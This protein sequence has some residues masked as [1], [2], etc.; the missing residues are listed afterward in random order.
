M[1]L[2]GQNQRSWCGD[3]SNPPG[4]FISTRVDANPFNGIPILEDWMILDLSAEVHVF[5]MTNPGSHVTHDMHIDLVQD[6]LSIENVILR[7]RDLLTNIIKET[8]NFAS[9]SMTA[10]FND[11]TSKIADIERSEKEVSDA[12]SNFKFHKI[13][14]ILS[15]MWKKVTN[16]NQLLEQLEN[17]LRQFKN[18]T[19]NMTTVF[20]R[21]ELTLLKDRITNVVGKLENQVTNALKDFSGAGLKFGMHL[22]IFG[23]NFGRIDGELV[24]SSDVLLRCSRF[25]GVK[26]LLQN[27]P[28]LR[29]LGRFSYETKLGFF[30]RCGN[31]AGIGVAMA[32][33]SN[34]LIVQVNGYINILGIK[35]TGDV[36]IS[37]QGV[38]FYI[39]GKVWNLF[40]AQLESHAGLIGTDWHGLEISVSGRFVAQAR[41]KRQTQTDTTN[42]EAS[43]LDALRKVVSNIADGVQKRLSQAQSALTYAQRKMTDAK[44]WLTEK[45]RD[46]RNANS[47]FDSAVKSFD[48][49]KDKL[50]AAKGPFRRAIEKLNS[51][52]RKVDNLCRIRHCKKIC[53]PG[54]KCKICHK[55]ILFV[56]VPYPCCHFTRCMISFP[57]PICSVANLGCKA[58]RAIAYA[59]LEVAK[60]FVRAPM[61]ALDAAKL[62]LSAAQVVVDK[63]RVV[64]KVAEGAI[65]LAKLGLEATK[66]G[67]ELAKKALDGL[68]AVIGAAAK[69]LDSVIRFGLQN[70]MDVRN[71]GFLVKISTVDIFVFD[72]SCEINAFRLG[73]R[74]VGVRIN[75]K[76]IL[77]SLW[78]AAKAAIKGLMHLIG[79]IFTGRRRREIESDVTSKIH[80]LIR[81]I[82]SDDGQWNKTMDMINDT[83]SFVNVTDAYSGNFASDRDDRVSIFRAKCTDMRRHLSF[84]TD[85]LHA[86]HDI[87][88]E[89]KSSLDLATN[90]TTD[91]DNSD[92]ALKDTNFTAESLGI[93]VDYAHH[94]N[95]SKHDIE[96]TLENEKQ[97]LEDNQHLK[98]I[99]N[100]TTFAKEIVNSQIQSID[101]SGITDTW[102][103]ALENITKMHFNWSECVDFRDCVLF[104][105]SS[106]YDIYAVGD[107]ANM[108]NVRLILTDLEDSVLDIVRNS[109]FNIN[110]IHNSTT[111]IKSYL[112]QID[113]MNIFC[114]K[115]PKLLSSPQ[116]VTTI[117]GGNATFHC[118]LDSETEAYY[119]WYRDDKLMPNERSST[120]SIQNVTDAT[121]AYRCEAGNIVT[122]ITSKDIFI[123]FVSPDGSKIF[124]LLMHFLKY[125]VTLKCYQVSLT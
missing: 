24:Y 27:Q 73:W 68:K 38:R 47:A 13:P 31:G 29:M 70:I 56:N 35:V 57:D 76:N 118:K 85:T 94:Y 43:Y 69:V 91:I 104:S 124:I 3:L 12:V 103:L 99:R 96:K 66:L 18:D 92:Q 8:G 122:N 119:W 97:S 23:L 102:M 98:D 125:L 2:T 26:K 89:S 112:Y 51:A 107:H 86:L 39:E 50:E 42:F 16:F 81:R 59:G 21:N 22:K 88:S 62:T 108:T 83:L 58:I 95:L 100:M 115:P 80:V 30:I 87:A 93:N 75:F 71:C 1:N 49:A 6:V 15:D 28:A 61:L 36:F 79:D 32:L 60:A 52:Q 72:V 64:L 34:D 74:K 45:K 101:L 11:T 33:H 55:K 65:E 37:R 113:E 82:R 14:G 78:N 123:V 116:N 63:S 120:L 20:L 17:G 4:I 5:L 106:M 53:I 41:T 110:G 48:R 77:Q 109:S 90:L 114:T 46:V 111:K 25:K 121:L 7:L 40:Y 67:L 117:P 44:K 84:L 19:L 105:I 54:L 9:S 10:I